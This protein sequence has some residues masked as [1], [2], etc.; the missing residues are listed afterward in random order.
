LE[1]GKPP[2]ADKVAILSDAARLLEELRSEA[3]K[4][5]TSN[6]SL[7]DSIKSLKVNTKTL[8]LHPLA[9]PDTHSS[10]RKV[11]RS[12]WFSVTAV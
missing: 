3:Q 4:L 7:Q 2:K 11:Q 8:H 6:E 10:E 1:P 5:K 9:H 12:E